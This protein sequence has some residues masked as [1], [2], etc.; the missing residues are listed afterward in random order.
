[1]ND[2]THNTVNVCHDNQ[3]IRLLRSI[4]FVYII[5]QCTSEKI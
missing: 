1:M 5:V 2:M 4:L 3:T